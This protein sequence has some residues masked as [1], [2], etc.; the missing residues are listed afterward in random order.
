MVCNQ[1]GRSYSRHLVVICDLCSS[2]SSEGE[3]GWVSVGFFMVFYFFTSTFS[4]YTFL[5]NLSVSKKHKY[6]EL[7]SHVVA[8]EVQNAAA[9]V[10]CENL[11]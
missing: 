7:T 1:D 9:G 4:S 3:L 11:V 2:S 6:W 5:A 8:G 10:V